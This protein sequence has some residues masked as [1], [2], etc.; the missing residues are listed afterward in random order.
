MTC[1]GTARNSVASKLI[2]EPNTSLSFELLCLAMYH[3]SF[4]RHPVEFMAPFQ[5]AL[6]TFVLRTVAKAPQV[7]SFPSLCSHL[8]TQRV[9]TEYYLGFEG[10]FGGHKVT[11][12]EL[13]ARHLGSLVCVE[14][15][16]TKCECGKIRCNCT[17]A[18]HR[19]P[20]STKARTL[21]PLL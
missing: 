17:N 21:R 14:G 7:H 20:C 8:L 10:S 18:Y 1:V 11:P 19:H 6:R 9:Q 13:V 5:A 4:L 2:C 15:I 3:F 16:V 12:R